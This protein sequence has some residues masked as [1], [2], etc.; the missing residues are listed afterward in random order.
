MFPEFT[1]FS[2]SFFS[3]DLTVKRGF[4]AREV[5]SL[6]MLNHKKDNIAYFYYNAAGDVYYGINGEDKGRFFSGVDTR[7]PVWVLID[8]YGETTGI[9]FVGKFSC[10]S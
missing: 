7:G 4:W 8:I 3:S 1:F 2:S 9:E 6:K 10:I 5:K